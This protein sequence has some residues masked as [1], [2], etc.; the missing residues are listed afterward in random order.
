MKN[1]GYNA[2]YDM[3]MHLA[4]SML[5]GRSL[6]ASLNERPVQESKTNAQGE[7]PGGVYPPTNL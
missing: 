4:Q 5:A 6:E 2:N 7:G 3:V 1:H